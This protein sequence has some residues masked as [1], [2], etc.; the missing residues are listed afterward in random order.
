MKKEGITIVFYGLNRTNFEIFL[1]VSRK[2]DFLNFGHTYNQELF[3][4]NKF[5]MSLY[6][7][8]DE[9]QNNFE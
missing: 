4:E 2:Y 9:M 6:K 1:Q 3:N 8:F 5:E 7:D